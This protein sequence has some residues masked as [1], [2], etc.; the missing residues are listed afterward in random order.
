MGRVWF[1]IKISLILSAFALSAVALA[2]YISDTRYFESLAGEIIGNDTLTEKE[3][4]ERFVQFAFE[5]LRQAS[6]EELPSLWH[7][8]YY[9]YN[10]F[11]PSARDVVKYGG[12]HTGSCGSYSR[13]VVALLSEVDIPARVIILRDEND[14]SLHAVVNARIDGRWRVADPLYGIVF[15]KPDGGLAT[16]DDL[17]EDRDLLPANANRNPSYPIDVFTYD[18]F[19]LMNWEKIPV[20]MPAVRRLLVSVIG[21]QRTA[22][23]ARPRIW[24]YPLAAFALIFTTFAA[25][26]VAVVEVGRALFRAKRQRHG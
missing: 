12:H 4:F 18:N 19:A 5:E 24:M 11:H 26:V 3:T 7:R 23:I 25:V 15:T 21:E 1:R 20:V 13:V 16:A 9:K 8:L 6:Y 10:P 17:R 2:S 14:R 22:S